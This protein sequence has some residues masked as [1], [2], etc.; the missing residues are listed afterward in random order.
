M[1]KYNKL[2]TD[3]QEKF[4]H[5]NVKGKSA[6]ELANLVNN[7]FNLSVSTR[8]IESY[9]TTHGIKS[10]IWDEKKKAKE[11][12]NRNRIHIKVGGKWR[13]KH[14]VIWEEANGKVPE[15]HVLIFADQNPM[16]VTLDNLI[17]VSR[18]QLAIINKKKLLQQDKELNQIA[19]KIADI[20]LKAA[21]RK[22][23]K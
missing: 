20:T 17:L 7:T 16:N 6:K 9:K 22:K 21:E 19:I 1:R 18:R 8:Q 13:L 4:I 12:I 23:A 14:V 3:E 5:E 15:G 2:F 11:F 10:G